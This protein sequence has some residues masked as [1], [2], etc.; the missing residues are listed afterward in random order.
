MNKTVRIAAIKPGQTVKMELGWKT[1]VYKKLADNRR[2][3]IFRFD[4]DWRWFVW[5]SGWNDLV[6][7]MEFDVTQ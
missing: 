3:L 7:M 4:D 5:Q 1:V 6:E 2:T